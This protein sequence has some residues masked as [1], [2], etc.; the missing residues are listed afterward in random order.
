MT[1]PALLQSDTLLLQALAVLLVPP[2][3]S[4]PIG[5]VWA[6]GAILFL[7]NLFGGLV[8]G[9][10]GEPSPPDMMCLE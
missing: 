5:A 9:K 1:H 6:F 7:I 10:L 2:A 4:G 3:S 8:G